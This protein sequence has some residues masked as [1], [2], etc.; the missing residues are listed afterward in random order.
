MS[1]SFPVVS[2]ESAML[3]EAKQFNQ[4]LIATIQALPDQ[5]Q[6]PPS[7]TRER[8]MQGSSTFPAPELSPN[9]ETLSIPGQRQPIPLR[10]LKAPSGAPDGVMMH[11]HGGGFVFGSASFQDAYL[12]ARSRATNLDIISVDYRLAPE[13]PFPAGLDDCVAAALWITG[14]GATKH[15]WRKIAIAGESS[16]ANLALSTL[17]RLRDTYKTAPFSCAAFLSGF[18]DLGLTPSARNWGNK[19]LLITTRDLNLFAKHYLLNGEDRQHPEASP[20]FAELHDLPPSIVTAGTQDPLLDDSLFL[21]SRL[22]A[23]NSDVEVEIY[24]NGCHVFQGFELGLAKVS[25]S[26]IDT[27]IKK[28]MASQF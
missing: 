14:E 6:F 25:L 18:F 28:R 4:N 17:V 22:Q 8:R 5:W 3:D 12:E 10:L 1:F 7:V 21:T 11:I 15:G 27:F 24:P 16:G 20:L 9:A 26:S 13:H 2:V 23:T 19:P